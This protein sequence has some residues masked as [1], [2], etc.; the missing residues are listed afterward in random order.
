MKALAKW[1]A[2]S[3]VAANVLMFLILLGGL[4]SLKYTQREM[5]PQFALDM[6]VVTVPYPGASPEE[7][8]EGICLKIEEQLDGVE[9]LKEITSTAR[10]GAGVVMVELETSANTISVYNDIKN[11]VDGIDAFP[12]E[13]E[14]PIITSV[15][16]R[17][18]AISVP[19]YGDASEKVLRQTA[20]EVEQELKD[21]DEVTM[22]NLVGAREYEISVEFR[23]EDLR[24]YGLTFETVSAE[25]ARGSMDLPAGKIR[26]PQ[27]EIVVRAKGQRYTGREFGMIPILSRNDGAIIRLRDVADIIDGFEET[28]RYSRYA[29]KRANIIAVET[30]ETQDIITVVDRVKKY[31]EE[32]KPELKARGLGIDAAFDS[33]VLV[34]DRI[35][36]LVRNG[37]Q[38]LILVF[39]VLGLFLRW[40]LAFWVGMGIPISFMGAFILLKAFDGT[41]N[42]ISLFAFIMVLGIVVDDAIIVGE[43]IHSHFRHGASPFKATVE[44]TSEVALPVSIAVLTTMV[45]FSPMLFVT[46]IMGK[47]IFI[48]PVVVICTL[49]VSLLEAFLILPSHLCHSLQGAVHRK[50]EQEGW[51]SRMINKMIDRFYGPYLLR[52]ALAWRY[53]TLFLSIGLIALS[54]GLF[55]GGRVQFT[56]FPKFDS[57]YID[58]TVS[59]PEGTPVEVTEDAIR[60]MEEAVQRVA[61][62]LKDKLDPEELK[63]G[64]C[65]VCSIMSFVGETMRRGAEAGSQGGHLGQVFVQLMPTEYRDISSNEILDLWR[66][67]TGVIPGTEKLTFQGAQAGP[68]GKPI[69]V[70]LLGNDLDTLEK[71]ADK[72]KDKLATYQGVFDITDDFSPGK[73]E[74]T[75]TAKPAAQIHELTLG[76]I[77]RQVRHGFYGAEAQRIQRGKNEVEVMVRYTWPERRTVSQM[78]AIRIRTTRGEE[79]P[80]AEVA[81][82]E[83]ARGYSTIQRADGKRAITV[84]ADI[85]EAVANARE[86]LNSLTKGSAENSRG[87]NGEKNEKEMPFLPGLVQQYQGVQFDLEGQAKTTRESVGSL[88]RGFQFA[89]IAIF[90]L[91]A[92]QFRSYIQ[93]VIIMFAIPVSLTGAVLGHLLFGTNLSLMSLFGMVA[94]AGIVINDSLVLIDFINRRVEEGMDVFEAVVASGKA[95]FRAIILT[96]MTTIAGLLPM[97]LERS[98]QAQFLLPMAISLAFGLMTST[99]LTLVVTP[100]LY[101]IVA[102]IKKALGMKPVRV[103]ETE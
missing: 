90:C 64:N 37:I 6:I 63:K 25:I 60:Q 70:R 10:E 91:L 69:A 68:G 72:L 84:T 1:S 47:F 55:L 74:I 51:R 13:S 31:V 7:V 65:L 82:I 27:G 80:L 102:D 52:P 32:K 73:W 85:D 101:M 12:Q 21:T 2:S 77:A 89:L 58:A 50:N 45:A 44:G 39:L 41:I 100:S 83:F 75:L 34:R 42:M 103:I 28:D 43:N 24:R 53:V 96:S 35:S 49:G 38:G 92:G 81:N 15:K 5:F 56:V 11:E 93:P 97:L 99:V 8:E 95:R 86:I 87:N 79:V 4:M 17:N 19:V 71:A 33:S 57:D 36:L 40:R 23:E 46:G 54:I 59:F 30:T 22:T 94:L 61:E 98:M 29:G 76:D 14:K 88:V 48:M 78:E 62:K 67:E 9:G 20:E 26:T 18:T 3:P 16:I 66:E